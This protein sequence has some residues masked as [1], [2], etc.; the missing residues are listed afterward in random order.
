MNNLHL[1]VCSSLTLFL[2]FLPQRHHHPKFCLKK[3]DSVTNI[4]YLR[5]YY[6]ILLFG[7]SLKWCVLYVIFLDLLFF[8][9]SYAFHAD[10]PMLLYILIYVSFVYCCITIHCII[11]CRWKFKIF[12]LVFYSYEESCSQ[13]SCIFSGTYA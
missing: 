3:W 9:Q 10:L 12:F 13:H 5:I 2:W 4:E 8:S 6:L 7:S 11:Y 1:L